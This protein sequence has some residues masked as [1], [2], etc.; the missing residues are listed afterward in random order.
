MLDKETVKKKLLDML[1]D[2]N[3][4]LGKYKELRAK[5]LAKDNTFEAVLDTRKH[6]IAEVL[7][8][9]SK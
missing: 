1:N 8:L 2:C 7:E 3:E 6:I 9:I 4:Q 5:G